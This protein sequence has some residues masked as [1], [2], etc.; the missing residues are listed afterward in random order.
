MRKSL[1]CGT[2]IELGGDGPLPDKLEARWAELVTAVGEEFEAH[3]QGQP[4]FD[5]TFTGLRLRAKCRGAR[6]MEEWFEASF[7][8]T[9]LLRRPVRQLAREFYQAYFACT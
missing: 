9:E 1:G 8:P 5:H 2:A 6:S 4:E 7:S 3:P